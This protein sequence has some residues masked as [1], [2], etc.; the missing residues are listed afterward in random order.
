MKVFINLAWF[1]KQEKRAYIIGIIMLFGVALL[2]LVAPKVLG[3]VVD[4]I[5]NGTLTSEKLLKWVILLVV[6]GITMYILRYLWRI[7]IF[8]SSLKLA[9]QLRKNLYEHFTKMSPSFYQSRRTGDLMAHATNDIQAIQQT[10]GSGVLTLVDSLAVGGCVLVAMGFTIS[11]KLTLLS[12]IPMPIVAISTNY[13]GTLLHKRFHK[14]Q[15]SFSEINDKVQESMSGMKVIR[16]LGQEKEDLQAFRKKSEDVVHK[17]MLVARIDS[18]FDPTISLIVGFSFLIAVCYGSV[19]VV[20]GELTV[21]DLVTFTTYLG[22]LVWPMLA[23]GWLFNIMERGRASYDRVEKILSQKSDVVNREDAV[24]TIASGDVT[25]AVD[26]FSYKKN[27]LLQLIDVHFDLKKG[28]TLGVVGRTGAGK[29]TLLK[30]LIREY[31]HFNGGLKVG[32]RDI[33]DVTLYG[34]R[35]AI[36]YVPQDHFLFSASIGENIAFGR[37]DATYNEITR[38]AEIACIHDDILQFSEGYETVVGE[39][40]VSLSGGQKQR[41]SIARALLTDAEILILDDCLSAVDAKTEETIL[42]A[43]KRERAGKTTIITAHRL[44]A[45]QHANLILVV[46]EGRIVQRGTHEQLMEE[47]G[48]YK[49]MYESQQLEALVEKG[50]V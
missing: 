4:E 38:A 8:G 5:N 32:E 26:S 10:A 47:N 40:G 44:S 34:V 50:G 43:L 7:M 42:N 12:L 3:I 11:W 22:T 29:T 49:E 18:L 9:R 1:F 2:E 16:S 17:N 31:D 24:H 25:F 23:F 13:Y 6:V 36:S 15:Q 46:D 27:E 28:E 14:A 39:R 20:R 45:I 35:S 30:C 21:G 37:A 48:W 19:L 33:R 41:I